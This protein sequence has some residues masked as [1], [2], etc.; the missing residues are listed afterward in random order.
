[1]DSYEKRVRPQ[2][3]KDQQWNTRLESHEEENL[4]ELPPIHEE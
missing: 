1:M 4:D 2:F 3:F